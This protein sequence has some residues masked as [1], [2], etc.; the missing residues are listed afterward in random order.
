MTDFYKYPNIWWNS[1]TF[2][3]VETQTEGQNLQE[4]LDHALQ[5]CEKYKKRL[6]QL[7]VT[8][9]REVKNLKKSRDEFRSK[10]EKFEASFRRHKVGC[11]HR[12]RTL[13]NFRT[14]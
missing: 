13:G 8:A 10:C 14:I 12:N 7:T 11:P 9:K 5:E 1:R 2:I 3:S 6:E 4:K